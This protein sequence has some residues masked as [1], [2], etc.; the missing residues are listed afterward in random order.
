MASELDLIRTIRTAAAK[1]APGRGAGRPPLLQLGIGDDCA[2]LRPREGEDLVVT[3][4]FTLE[5]R[6]FHRELHPPASV[7]HRALAR[8]L[9][10]IAA[11]GGTP[12]TAFLSLA[13]PAPVAADE[14][15]VRAFTQG[16]LQLARASGVTLA[17]G[18]TSEAP[19]DNVLADI[20]V[21][22]SVPRGQ[23]LRRGG[24]K[25]GDALYCTG[26]LGGAAEELHRLLEGMI[27][28][29]GLVKRSATTPHPHFYP[30]PRLSAGQALLQ[31]GVATA[32][33]DLSDG[34][35]TDLAH[36]CEASGVAA[37]VEFALIPKPAGVVREAT[38][39][40]REWVLNGG[41]DYELLFTCPA[42][43]D[44]PKELGGVAVTRLG[45]ITP[46]QPGQP[47]VTL[48]END[49]TRTPL[50]PG[51]WEHFND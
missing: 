7:A 43:A 47:K 35:S 44:I 5:G 24:A 8:G 17:G 3:T 20:M 2:V 23:A 45:R 10:D 9:S 49:G 40:A 21:V 33:I 50:E 31:L 26:S 28:H 39:E 27:A 6:H 38:A 25:A 22:G 19:G 11:M 51:G 41:E 42:S 1:A 30:E 36:L 34:L 18:D 13:L 12:E 4:D 29:P 46:A 32:C 16:L 48:I 14:A 15:W 37:K